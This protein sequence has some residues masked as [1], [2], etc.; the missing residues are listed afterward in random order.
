M[1]RRSC[2]EREVLGGLRGGRGGDWGWDWEKAEEEA[3]GSRV[4]LRRWRDMAVVVV[5]GVILRRWVSG[6]DWRQRGQFGGGRNCEPGNKTTRKIGYAHTILV[7]TLAFWF[8]FQTKITCHQRWPNGGLARP[9]RHGPFRL[10]YYRA[11]IYRFMGQSDGLSTV[12]RAF[13]SGRVGP[14]L[15]SLLGQMFSV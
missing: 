12:H 5:S 8:L 9:V 4:S 15:F 2:C 1:R 6:G 11:V 3:Q 7:P 14:S 10:R 13:V